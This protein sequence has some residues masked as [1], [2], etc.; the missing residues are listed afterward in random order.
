MHKSVRTAISLALFAALA[1]AGQAQR[2][3]VDIETAKAN[4]TRCVQEISWYS[5]LPTTLKA[6][7][8]QG[9]LV[10]WMHMLGNIFADT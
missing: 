2:G 10:F 3:K 8:E 6:A 5:S 9:K 4:A 1:A 7:K